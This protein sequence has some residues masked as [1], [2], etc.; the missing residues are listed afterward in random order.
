MARTKDVESRSP[1]TREKILEAAE[2]IMA[3]HGVE[4]FQLKDVAEAVGIRPPSIYAHFENR[5][6]IAREVTYRIYGRIAAEV[7]LD[8]DADPMQALLQMLESYVHFLVSQPACL[9]LVLH[10]LAYTAFPTTD[11]NHPSKQDAW[12]EISDAF[13]ALVQR[14]I[15]AGK[16][17]RVRPEGVHA[18]LTGATAASLCWQGWDEDGNPIAGVPVAEIVRETQD[19]AVRLLRIAEE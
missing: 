5:D 4:G 7:G 17:R 18:Q 12:Q 16:F 19:L 9:R 6:A 10:D 8:Q 14:G 13:T 3:A 1:R 2:R 11:P 15:E